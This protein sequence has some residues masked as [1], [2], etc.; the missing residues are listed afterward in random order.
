MHHLI[1]KVFTLPDEICR[2]F[3]F[4]GNSSAYMR[5]KNFH[6]DNFYRNYDNCESEF[7]VLF[8]IW[9]NLHLFT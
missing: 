6:D 5:K 8:D 1:Y 9:T 4:G 7:D 2:G 3:R